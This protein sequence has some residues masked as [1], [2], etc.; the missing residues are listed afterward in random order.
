MIANHQFAL[1]FKNISKSFGDKKVN[2]NISF[3]VKAGH[4][5]ALIGEN[6]AGKSTLMKILFGLHQAESG[7]IFVRGQKLKIQSPIAAKQAGF[8]MVHQ[9]FMLAGEI[10]ALDHMILEEDDQATGILN[11]KLWK[12]LDRKKI[13]SQ[14]EEL[15]QRYKMPVPW[16][17]PIHKLSVGIQ[18]RIEI[19]KI[20]KNAA[21]FLILDEPTAVLNPIETEELLKRIKQLKSEGKTIILI[22]HKLKEI[23][24]VADD[25]TVLRNGEM[26]FS[27][28][29]TGQ[30]CESLGELMVGRKLK[31][32]F[33]ENSST[34]LNPA[35]GTTAYEALKVNNLSAKDLGLELKDIS[36]E[37][38]SGE[39]LG[40][41]GVEGNGQSLLLKCLLRPKDIAKF[42][43]SIFFRK[44][45]SNKTTAQIRDLS[46]S[47]LAE[48]RLSQAVIAD[49]NLLE[50]FFLGMKSEN[51]LIP[52]ANLEENLEK[53]LKDFDVRP[54]NPKEILKN[55]SG[56]NQQKF[57]IAREL[58]HQ[59]KLLIAAQPT[60][61]V[62]VGAIEQIHE[63][64]MEIKKTGVAILLVSSELD[65]L[66]KLSDRIVVMNKGRISEPLAK[67]QFNDS[68]IAARLGVLMGGSSDSA[69]NTKFA[70]DIG[71]Q[72]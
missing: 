68:N 42:S 49:F 33:S 57:V 64:L 2:N 10:S 53:Q 65:E 21:D 6:G 13:Q 8:G 54:P 9:H 44:E 19:L 37:V 36:F 59:P 29:I 1:E 45:L 20:L 16:T 61:G 71:A 25:F 30:T 32:D 11:W 50:N 7:E 63:K 18:Q 67:S 23:I 35:Q 56:G 4:V 22:S 41:A 27:G 31:S 5:H 26:I 12:R 34:N 3:Q 17:E 62:D 47:Y 40:I 60:R 14:L 24:S 43:G 15:S 38:K 48:D 51:G 70:S 58:Q 69:S 66:L 39:I 55:L 28:P 46:V 52:W 72:T